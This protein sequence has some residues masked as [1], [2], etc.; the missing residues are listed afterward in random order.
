MAS[1]ICGMLRANRMVCGHE[2]TNF[3]A[4]GAG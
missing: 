1:L 4:G 3:G 2:Q